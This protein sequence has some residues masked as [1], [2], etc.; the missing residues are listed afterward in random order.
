MQSNQ[1]GLAKA[2]IQGAEDRVDKI[3]DQPALSD[4]DFR[5]RG[6]AGDQTEIVRHIA[7]V[8]A[9]D[10]EPRPVDRDLNAFRT[11]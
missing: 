10:G 7:Q 4:L 6:H 2:F 5:A 11:G 3:R 9:G 8:A 1:L